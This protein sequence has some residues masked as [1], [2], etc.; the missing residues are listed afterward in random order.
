MDFRAILTALT[1]ADVEF[2]VI[3]GVSAVL[4]G[5]PTTTFDLDIVPAR[6]DEN[7]RRLFG[8]LQALEACYREHL[9]KRLAPTEQHLDSDGHMLLMTSA[10]PLD[11]L[12]RVTGGQ[13]Y[14]D[15]VERSRSLDLGSGMSV[16]ILDLDALIEIKEMTGREKDIAQLPLLR[17]ALQERQEP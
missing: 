5:V 17:R 11:V 8:V 1:E 16:R 9:P 2:V 10:G 13:T 3:G 12:G 4:H 7:R 6:S 14:E 15:L